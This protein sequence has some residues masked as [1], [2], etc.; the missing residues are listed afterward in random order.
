MRYGQMR[1]SSEWVG[2][3]PHHRRARRY[4][5]EIAAQVIA[6]NPSP[7]DRPVRTFPALAAEI[8]RPRPGRATGPDPRRHPRRQPVCAGGGNAGPLRASFQGVFSTYSGT[9]SRAD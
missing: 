8:R 4:Q 7:G 9:N 3:P 2:A 6:R 5:L 1:I